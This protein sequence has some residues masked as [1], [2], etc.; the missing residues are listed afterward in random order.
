MTFYFTF[1]VINVNVLFFL[2]GDS[3]SYSYV[4]G[5]STEEDPDWRDLLFLAKLIPRILHNINRVCYIFGGPVR[6]SINDITETRISRYTLAQLRQ[7][8]HVANTVRVISGCSIQ[9]SLIIEHI[10][11]QNDFLLVDSTTKWLHVENFTNAC[12]INTNSF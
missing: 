6:F 4:L 11:N 12:G 5:L 1:E 2:L 8:D 7:A 3:R 9:L 10:F